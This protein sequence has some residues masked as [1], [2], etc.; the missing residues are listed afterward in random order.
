MACESGTNHP[1]LHHGYFAMWLFRTSKEV[2][3]ISYSL[4]QVW[5][6][7]LLW[8]KKW[9]HI[10]NTSKSSFAL[11]SLVGYQV[12]KYGYPATRW[13]PCGGTLDGSHVSLSGLWVETVYQSSLTYYN[14]IPLCVVMYGEEGCACRVRGELYVLPSHS[15]CESKTALSLVERLK[16]EKHLPSKTEALS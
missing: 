5:L 14:N 12:N 4:N 13:S 8:A 1:P 10:C 2:E 9:K 16:G 6:C 15:S 3:P 11:L 7:Y